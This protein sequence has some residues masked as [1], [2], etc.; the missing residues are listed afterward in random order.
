MNSSNMGI[1]GGA[2]AVAGDGVLD[3]M[4]DRDKMIG[5]EE[6][7]KTD[8]ILFRRIGMTTDVVND[9]TVKLR[10]KNGAEITMW[11]TVEEGVR[12]TDTTVIFGIMT[13]PKKPVTIE[14]M[15]AHATNKR[16]NFAD[17]MKIAEN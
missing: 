1:S 8:E 2:A 5:T 10:I 13:P 4:I 16:L 3:T 15:D 11:I 14:E 6:V 12:Q 17:V 7:A 9:K